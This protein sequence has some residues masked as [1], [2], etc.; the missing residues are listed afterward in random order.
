MD[1]E[2]RIDKQA[3]STYNRSNEKLLFACKLNK[4]TE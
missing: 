4:T 2:K 1:V 3:I